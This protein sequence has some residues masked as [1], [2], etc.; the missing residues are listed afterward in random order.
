M[1]SRNHPSLA[2]TIVELMVVVAIITLLAGL[3]FSALSGVRRTA[4][5]TSSMS[6]MRQIHLWMTLHSDND[7]DTVPPIQFDYTTAID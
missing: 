2:C 5:K 6:N 1:P 7:N 3:L 4:H